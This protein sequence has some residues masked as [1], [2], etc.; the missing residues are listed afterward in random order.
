MTGAREHRPQLDECLKVLQSGDS[1]Q[2]VLK[3]ILM[4]EITEITDS[5]KQ[6]CIDT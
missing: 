5:T 6:H 1:N 3:T 2:N 4:Q